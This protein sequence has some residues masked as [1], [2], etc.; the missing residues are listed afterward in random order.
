MAEP[1]APF[2]PVAKVLREATIGSPL[3]S[4]SKA[5]IELELYPAIRVEFVVKLGLPEPTN[6][7]ASAPMDG[8]F[9][10]VPV[11][12]ISYVPELLRVTVASYHISEL[13]EVILS[14]PAPLKPVG[15]NPRPPVEP[16]TGVVSKLKSVVESG[17]ELPDLI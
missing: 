11:V 17:D 5:S 8:K 3:L 4:K 13:Y 2:N 7:I 15:T 10:T 16:T 9:T 12:W 14:L 1:V 6:T